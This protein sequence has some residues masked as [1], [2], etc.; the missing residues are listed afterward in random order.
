MIV[1]LMMFKDYDKMIQYV[2]TVISNLRETADLLEA[3]SPEPDEAIVAIR[4]HTQNMI[5]N[6]ETIKS[7]LESMKSSGSKP[8]TDGNGFNP[9]LVL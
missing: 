9:L 6:A 7:K 2:D 5:T 1:N 8:T 4:E 3:A